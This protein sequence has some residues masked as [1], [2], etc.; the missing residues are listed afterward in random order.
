VHANYI[1]E[2][3]VE[4]LV[5][6]Y[7]FDALMVASFAGLVFKRFRNFQAKRMQRD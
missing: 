1:G 2:D 4:N 3:F 5:I 7:L 6:R